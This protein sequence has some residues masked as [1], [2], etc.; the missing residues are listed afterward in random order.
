M[1]EMSNTKKQ[2]A[3]RSSQTVTSSDKNGVKVFEYDNLNE[4]DAEKIIEDTP[5][6]VV[7]MGMN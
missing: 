3:E 7:M 1:C 5:V 4:D 6:A 2:T